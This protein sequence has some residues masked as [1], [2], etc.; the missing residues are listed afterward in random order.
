MT[1]ERTL[2]WLAKVPDDDP[3]KAA[4][5]DPFL[6]ALEPDSI[7]LPGV[8]LGP[9]HFDRDGEPI[10]L[11]QWALLHGQPDYAIVKQEEVG[12]YWV[13]TVWL[14]IDHGFSMR[15]VPIIFETMVFSA[16]E[17]YVRPQETP[18]GEMGGYWVRDDFDQRRYSTEA[19]AIAGHEETVQTFRERAAALGSIDP[20][21]ETPKEG[22]DGR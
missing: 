8:R 21:S 17:H 1:S 12:P 15:G 18:W 20:R 9:T 14:G 6:D 2:E 19:Q 11:R 13:S 4:A 3:M 16:D 7:L 22:D 5:P 10:T